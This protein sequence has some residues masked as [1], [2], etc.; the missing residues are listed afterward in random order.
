MSCKLMS[1]DA[2]PPM[3]T[4]ASLCSNHDSIIFT[5]ASWNPSRRSFVATRAARTLPNAPDTSLQQIA[6]PILRFNAYNHPT[7]TNA[8]ASL[9]PRLGAYAK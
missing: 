1:F 7:V 4:L 8:S 6:M 2:A 9:A 5:I 3:M